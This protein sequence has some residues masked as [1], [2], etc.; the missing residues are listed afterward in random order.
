M[1]GKLRFGRSR[2]ERRCGA[3]VCSGLRSV[4]IKKEGLEAQQKFRLVG[5][6][7]RRHWSYGFGVREAHGY[8]PVYVYVRGYKKCAVYRIL[9]L[10][11][12]KVS[13]VS[14]IL[15]TRE[16]G[17]ELYPPDRT[18]K[19]A[20]SVSAPTLKLLLEHIDEELERRG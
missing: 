11:D 19:G 20:P 1:G 3:L 14:C 6:G 2:G 10:Q 18:P 15:Y 12:T 17:M 5:S 13:I 9:C 4:Q 8:Q 7:F 16:G